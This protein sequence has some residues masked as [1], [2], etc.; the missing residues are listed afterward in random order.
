MTNIKRCYKDGLAHVCV[1]DLNTSPFSTIDQKSE[2]SNWFCKTIKEA[3]DEFSKITEGKM[4]LI[5]CNIS[6]DKSE[7]HF[8]VLDYS[9]N[10]IQTIYKE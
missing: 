6:K 8:G 9:N 1:L 10:P 4:H 3:S 2:F 7:I 5:S